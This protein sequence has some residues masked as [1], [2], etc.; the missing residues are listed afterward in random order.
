MRDTA[1]FFTTAPFSS[2]PPPSSAMLWSTLASFF[3]SIVIWPGGASAAPK[4]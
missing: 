3:D 2:M 4:S 1:P